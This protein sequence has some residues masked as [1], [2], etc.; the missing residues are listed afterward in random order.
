MRRGQGVESRDLTRESLPA[1]MLGGS[2]IGG[3][4]GDYPRGARAAGRA[5]VSQGFGR[6]LRDD[7][8]GGGARRAGGSRPRDR[9]RG[10]STAPASRGRGQRSCL[11]RAPEDHPALHG[12]GF[13]G[14]AR[15]GDGRV[16]AL[17]LLD[18]SVVQVEIVAGRR[19]F[20]VH[21]APATDGSDRKCSLVRPSTATPSRAS[22]RPSAVSASRTE[23]WYSSSQSCHSTPSLRRASTSR[24][25]SSRPA[26]V[27]KRGGR[28]LAHSAVGDEANH[29]V[30]VGEH[31]L[32]DVGVER[33]GH[34]RRRGVADATGVA[35][36]AAIEPLALR[37]APSREGEAAQRMRPAKQLE[38][39]PVGSA[40]RGQALSSAP[41]ATPARSPARD[42]RRG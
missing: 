36:T 9:L 4:A 27:V 18:P 12:A 29:P 30:D 3:A 35:P 23:R 28:P 25:K 40:A 15:D 14:L 39:L 8:A 31:D 38:W 20:V 11:A 19:Q 2:S 41:P 10:R 22:R 7:A 5:G 13:V 6:G 32:L 21:L 37:A 17:E 16:A 26:G 1:S 33:I 24:R 34:D 42:A